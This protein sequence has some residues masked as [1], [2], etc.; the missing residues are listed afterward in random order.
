MGPPADRRLTSRSV[1]SS[2]GTRGWHEC[3]LWSDAYGVHESGPRGVIPLPRA[4]QELPCCTRSRP[5]PP[6]P[7]APPRP[8]IGEVRG[9]PRG[10]TARPPGRQ[11]VAHRRGLPPRRGRA[12]LRPLQG[13]DGRP[14]RPRGAGQAGL[15]PLP[16]AALLPGARAGPARAVRGLGR[17]D[18]GRAPGGAGPAPAPGRGAANSGLRLGLNP[19]PLRFSSRG[20]SRSRCTPAAWR[21]CGWSRSGGSSRSWSASPASWWWRSP[22]GSAPR[23]AARRR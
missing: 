7:S 17:A 21:A 20:R 4:C 23:A 5:A 1:N 22:G 12:L 11:P 2:L 18:G 9:S 15:R 10:G 19:P 13:A 6:A 8:P 14:P 16:G 3:R